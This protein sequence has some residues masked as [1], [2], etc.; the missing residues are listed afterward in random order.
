MI[1]LMSACHQL[2]FLGIMNHYKVV[3]SFP[4]KIYTQSLKII[5]YLATLPRFPAQGQSQGLMLQGQGQHKAKAKT[6]GL[7]AKA[8]A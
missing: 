5:T 7:K 2:S 6:F 3:Y 8:K 4:Q 1:L